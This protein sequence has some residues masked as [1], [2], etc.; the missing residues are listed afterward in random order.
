MCAASCCVRHARLAMHLHAHAQVS[1]PARSARQPHEV[2]GELRDDKDGPE[3]LAL[4]QARVELRLLRRLG[5]S[6]I[7]HD[8]E[9]PTPC[10]RPVFVAPRA[11]GGRSHG[12][13]GAAVRGLRRRCA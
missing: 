6:R 11:L 5:G 12:P 2:A 13:D 10:R 7:R 3:H 4:R 9:A 1:M 8:E